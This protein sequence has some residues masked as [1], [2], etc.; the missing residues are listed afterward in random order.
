MS[1]YTLITGA[2]G[3]FGHGLISK[4]Y[5]QGTKIITLDLNDLDPTL[6]PMVEKSY[7]MDLMDKAGLDEIFA[8]YDFNQIY[9][10]AA[11][12]STSSE[13]I[14]YKACDINVIETGS[15]YG[16]TE[17]Y[18]VLRYEEEVDGKVSIIADAMAGLI[19][20]NGK[21]CTSVVDNLLK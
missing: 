9:H 3:E 15:P 4:L 21:D 17:K 6:V 18:S 19:K 11:L 8:T 13:R 14:P 1:Y 20:Y 16:S 2:N 5:A 7:K 10:L 12:L